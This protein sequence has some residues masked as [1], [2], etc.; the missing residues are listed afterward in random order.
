MEFVTSVLLPK[1]SNWSIEV[2][3]LGFEISNLL[4]SIIFNSIANHKYGHPCGQKL[5]LEGLV[6][7]QS[8][9]N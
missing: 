9:P 3:Y 8:T 6:P 2:W 1:Y 5:K 7:S 4:F